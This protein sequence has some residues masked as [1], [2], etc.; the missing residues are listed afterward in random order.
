MA[1]AN[2]VL[3]DGTKVTI[4]GTAD[5][6]AALL[7]KISTTDDYRAT[8]KRS[9]PRRGGTATKAAAKSAKKKASGPTDYIRELISE[10]YFKTKREIGT[11]RDKLEERAH[12]Y[13]VTSISGPL[14][15]LVKKKEL[16]RI[17]EDGA[18]KYVNP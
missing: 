6:V 17:K 12:I 4:D 13:P 8:S 1:K 16:R 11:V 15:R 2:L 18:W 5:E 3:P 10:G 14:Y 7:G 9:S